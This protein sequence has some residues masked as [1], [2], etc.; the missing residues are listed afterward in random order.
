MGGNVFSD[1]ETLHMFDEGVEQNVLNHLIIILPWHFLNGVNQEFL[2]TAMTL[3]STREV[4]WRT[5]T[6]YDAVQALI[7]VLQKKDHFTRQKVQQI[8]ADSNFEAKGGATGPIHFLY[9]NR[10]DL[11][12]GGDRRE[13]LI[14]LVKLVPNCFN[15]KDRYAFVPENYMLNEFKEKVCSLGTSKK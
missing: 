7:E 13:K 6:S 1:S 14:V 10:F 15:S 12:R 8:L 3:W 11:T 4:S 2:D 9:F 5:A